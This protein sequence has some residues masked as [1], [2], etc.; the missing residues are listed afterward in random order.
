MAV[1]IC[2]VSHCVLRV[3]LYF[4]CVFMLRAARVSDMA[5]M[6][7]FHCYPPVSRFCR[8]LLRRK[9]LRDPSVLASPT[10]AEKRCIDCYS[11][12]CGVCYLLPFRCAVSLRV[13]SIAF[14][15]IHL[16]SRSLRRCRACRLPPRSERS[17]APVCGFRPM[18]SPSFPGELKLA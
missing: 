11:Q 6:Q 4:E 5:L 1:L 18:P 9:P 17:P 13:R 14:L 10:T 7:R 12:T 16:Q 2:R 15:L 8:C 3:L